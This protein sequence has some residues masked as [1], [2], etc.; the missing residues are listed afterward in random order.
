L[1]TL[2]AIEIDFQAVLIDKNALVS[3]QQI[4]RE[5]Q[6]TQNSI[7]SPLILNGIG[8]GPM[9]NHSL[10]MASYISRANAAITDLRTLLKT[11]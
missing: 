5:L 8:F 6:N 11:G 9:S 10:I 7:W 3:L 4:I 2:Q 1:E